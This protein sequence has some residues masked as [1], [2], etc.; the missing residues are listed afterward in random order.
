MPMALFIFAFTGAY[1]HV[2]WMSPIISDV[3]LGFAMILLYILANL[4]ISDSYSIYAAMAMV[5]KTLMHSE[6]GAMVPLFMNPMFHNSMQ[7]Y[8]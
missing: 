4:Y 5:A 2:H 8:C 1:R 6:T 3:V 7:G